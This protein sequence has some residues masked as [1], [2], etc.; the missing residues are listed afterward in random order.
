L[1]RRKV[2]RK[3]QM[4]SGVSNLLVWRG[5]ATREGKK[6]VGLKNIE[7]YYLKKVEWNR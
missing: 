1:E 3:K 6:T 5:K 4:T 2:G 7:K